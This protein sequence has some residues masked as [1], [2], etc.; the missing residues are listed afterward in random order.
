MAREGS[1]AAVPCETLAQF[2]IRTPVITPMVGPKL[3]MFF[4][5]ELVKYSVFLR[6]RKVLAVTYVDTATM[7]VNKPLVKEEAGLVKLLPIFC[8][9]STTK[10]KEMRVLK[11]SSV[12]L[13][14]YLTRF[15]ADVMELLVSKKK[16][17]EEG[18]LC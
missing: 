11:I 2:A 16:E 8:T 10:M 4:L 18:L 7:R 12:N 15:D 14:K 13:V 3:D 9:A 5:T 6:P 17:R 1:A